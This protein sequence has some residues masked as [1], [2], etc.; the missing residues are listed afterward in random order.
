MKVK[1]II[2]MCAVMLVGCNNDRRSEEEIQ[3]SIQELS[4]QQLDR[5]LEYLENYDDKT[6]PN[7]NNQIK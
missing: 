3:E 2:L 1:I 4:E 6:K 5:M 7:Q